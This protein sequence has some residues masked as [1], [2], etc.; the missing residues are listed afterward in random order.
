MLIVA[1]TEGKGSTFL[2]LGPINL[3]AATKGKLHV[4]Q[5]SSPTSSL[6]TRTK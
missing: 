6:L 4:V 5:R 1:I 3:S 2:T